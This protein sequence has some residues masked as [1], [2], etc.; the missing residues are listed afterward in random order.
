MLSPQQVHSLGSWAIG[1]GRCWGQDSSI[2]LRISIV[3]SSVG[4]KGNPSLR[5][6][7]L[8]FMLSR[9]LTKLKDWEKKLP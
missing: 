6:M 4:F 2:G 8:F 1:S 7:C 3:C 5:E 9:V